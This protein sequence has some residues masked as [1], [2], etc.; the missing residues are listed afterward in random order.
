MLVHSPGYCD[1]LCDEWETREATP[2]EAAIIEEHEATLDRM[3]RDTEGRLH[4][5]CKIWT[6][7]EWALEMDEREYRQLMGE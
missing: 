3:A 2:E 7:K 5:P 6:E 1:P 4:P